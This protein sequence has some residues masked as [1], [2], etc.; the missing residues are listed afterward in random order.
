M[1][2]T[3]QTKIRGQVHHFGKWDP[4]VNGKRE[5]VPCDGWNEALEVYKAPRS[6]TPPS[7]PG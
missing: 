3:G 2:G 5:R 4:R 6:T 7:R 1:S